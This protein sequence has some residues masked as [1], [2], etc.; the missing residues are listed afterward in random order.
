[1]HH[2]MDPSPCHQQRSTEGTGAIEQQT[3]T[4]IGNGESSSKM[5]CRKRKLSFQQPTPQPSVHLDTGNSDDLY[6]DD[7]FFE[8]LDLDAIEAQATEKWKQKT[9]HLMQIQVEP[10]KAS[11]ISFAPPSFDLGFGELI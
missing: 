8:G 6:L 7:A 3:E 5:N 10:K 9:V 2:I 11:E 4:T 1:M